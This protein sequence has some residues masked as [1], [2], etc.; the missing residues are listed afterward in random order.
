V[1]INMSI[2]LVEGSTSTRKLA[3]RIV[4]CRGLS[5][6]AVLKGGS[7][8][9]PAYLLNAYSSNKALNVAQFWDVVPCSLYMNR[10]FGGTYHLHIEG[11]KSAKQGSNV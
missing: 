1:K 2:V 11:R 9:V 5:V 4:D 7:H 8:N 6:V 3:F 10:R